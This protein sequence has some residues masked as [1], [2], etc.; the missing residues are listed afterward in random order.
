MNFTHADLDRA[1]QLKMRILVIL[2][3]ISV[4]SDRSNAFQKITI[5][6]RPKYRGVWSE[7]GP[8]SDVCGCVRLNEGTINKS[9][10]RRNFNSGQ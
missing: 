2:L 4:K 6:E 1:I 7:W 8:W 5:E 9:C 3:P 10:V